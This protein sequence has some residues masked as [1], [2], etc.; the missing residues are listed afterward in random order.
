MRKELI[1]IAGGIGITPFRSMIEYMLDKKE[2]RK[3]VLFYSNKT[4]DEVCYK[5]LLER[6][7]KELGLKTVLLLN[8]NNAPS[9]MAVEIGRLNKEMI[10]KYVTNCPECLFYI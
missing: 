1:F 2:N 6:A 5:P 9:D 4:M 3:I 10:E 8:E 7:S